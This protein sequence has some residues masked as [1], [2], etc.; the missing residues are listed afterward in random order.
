MGGAGRVAHHGVLGHQIGTFGDSLRQLHLHIE[1]GQQRVFGIVEGDAQ[2][3]HARHRLH[4]RFG[5]P[6]LSLVL[7]CAAGR[8]DQGCGIRAGLF[9]LARPLP[10]HEVVGRLG[11]VDIDRVERADGGQRRRLLGADKCAGGRLRQSDNA[12][13]RRAHIGAFEFDLGAHQLRLRELQ[14]GVGGI[15]RG[16]GAVAALFRA[17][18]CLKQFVGAA[19]FTHGQIIIG[20]C[21]RDSR[22]RRGYGGD[23][24]VVLDLVELLAGLDPRTFVEQPLADD[25][26]HLRAHLRDRGCLDAAGQPRGHREILRFGFHDR[27]RRRRLLLRHGCKWGKPAQNQG[28]DT[29]CSA[30]CEPVSHGNSLMKPFLGECVCAGDSAFCSG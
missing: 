1:A 30:S 21:L 14:R 7:E 8:Q 23:I 20:L 25:A 9:R 5:R 22:L 19:G 18:L 3:D 26:G 16:V 17:G 12:G 4:L 24:G 15:A 29:R 28:E 10:A 27:Y 11:D 13:N 6:E 2:G